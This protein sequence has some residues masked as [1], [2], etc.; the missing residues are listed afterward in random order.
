M[1][2]LDQLVNK[3]RLLQKDEH[4]EEFMDYFAHF[5]DQDLETDGPS[6]SMYVYLLSSG[7]NNKEDVVV[8]EAIAHQVHPL[9][10]YLRHALGRIRQNNVVS[11]VRFILCTSA[12]KLLL[13]CL[14]AYSPRATT[15]RS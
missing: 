12:G 8:A 13:V 3:I 14:K 5:C 7:S 9:H 4:P 11:V 15:L 10:V 2:I 6:P 1:Q